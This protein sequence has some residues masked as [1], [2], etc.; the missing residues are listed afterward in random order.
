LFYENYVCGAPRNY[1]GYCNPDTDKLVDRQSTES[2]PG[3]C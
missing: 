1:T 3:K 2:D